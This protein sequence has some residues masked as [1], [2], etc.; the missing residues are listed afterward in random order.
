MVDYKIKG[1]LELVEMA[2]SH[3][4]IQIRTRHL[5]VCGTKLSTSQT[6]TIGRFAAHLRLLTRLSSEDPGTGT[7]SMQTEESHGAI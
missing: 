6:W 2:S 5:R 7:L 4:R 3:P 1:Y